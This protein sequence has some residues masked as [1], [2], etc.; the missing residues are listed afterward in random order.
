M[1]KSNGKKCHISGSQT[2][3]MLYKSFF[4]MQIKTTFQ[5]GYIGKSKQESICEDVEQ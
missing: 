2:Y 4:S 3:E 1:D 5:I